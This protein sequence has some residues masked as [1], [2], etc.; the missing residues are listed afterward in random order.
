V[1]QKWADSLL[2]GMFFH[3]CSGY[4]Q[5]EIRSITGPA[6]K[7]SDTAVSDPIAQYFKNGVGPVFSDDYRSQLLPIEMTINV[8]LIN[9]PVRTWVLKFRTRLFVS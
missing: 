3:S 4:P 9:P 5:I 2:A 7:I 8:Y 6:N 1:T